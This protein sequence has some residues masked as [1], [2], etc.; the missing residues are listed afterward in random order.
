MD[1]KS[2]RDSDDGV[3]ESVSVLD[4]VHLDKVETRFDIDPPLSVE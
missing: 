3:A 2:G 1:S 4:D